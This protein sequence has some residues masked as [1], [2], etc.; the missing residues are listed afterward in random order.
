MFLESLLSEKTGKNHKKKLKKTQK[1]LSRFW[2]RILL[3]WLFLLELITIF[4]ICNKLIS[5]KKEKQCSNDQTWVTYHPAKF[6][7]CFT[8]QSH[9]SKILLWNGNP[10]LNP[11][12][13]IYIYR[14][15]IW[16]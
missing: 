10:P 2:N 12:D 9:Q 16:I 13:P 11:M 4:E 6:N 1:I 5:K 7:K 15:H 14:A 3:R 8:K